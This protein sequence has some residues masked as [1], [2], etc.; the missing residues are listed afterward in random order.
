[1]SD[2]VLL[3]VGTPKTGTSYLQDVLFRNRVKLLREHGITYPAERFDAHFLAALDL[4]KMPWGGLQAEAIGAWDELAAAVRK[5]PGTAIISHEILAT[6]SRSQVKRALESIGYGSGTEVHVIL[7]VRDLVRQIPAEWQENVKHRG[8][9]QLRGLPRADP[10]PGAGQPDR[11]LV[12]GRPG[13]PRHPQPLGPRPAARARAP[14]HRAAARAPPD[15]LWKRF[16][17]AFGLDGIDLDLEAERV[18]PSLGVPEIALIRRINRRANKD[19]H[20]PDYRPLVRELLAHQT[21]SQR[22]SS[23]RLALPPDVHPWV[24][25]LSQSWVEEIRRRGYDVVGELDRPDR[26]A[27][28]DGLRRPRPPRRAPGR[29]RRPSTRSRRCC[30][31]TPGCGARRSGCTASSHEAHLALERSYLRPTY[32][33][34]EKV[35]R[36]L[37]RSLPGKGRAEGL[38]RGARQELAVGVA[39]DP[40][41]RVGVGAEADDAADDRHPARD[42]DREPLAGD[43]P[44]GVATVGAQADFEIDR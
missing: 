27:G 33:L 37:E 13:D 3:H 30:S 41:G 23:P 29:R 6:A 22:T 42:G 28:R 10:G 8:R 40:P 21:L 7:S 32:R 12:L 11:Q 34:R 9:P 26:R 24:Q 36:R 35:V 16:S 38:P 2:R 20:P 14:G 31:T 5:A 15:L 4:M 18:N 1:M 19:L 17:T 25:E 43:L 44:D 39:A